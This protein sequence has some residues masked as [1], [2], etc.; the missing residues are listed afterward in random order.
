MKKVIIVGATSGIGRGLA[1]LMAND[2]CMVGITGRR[3]RLLDE[4]KSEMPDNYQAETFDVSDIDS[5]GQH[6]RE[7]TNRL[8]GLDLL[9]IS[10][11]AGYLNDMLDFELEKQTIDTN[12]TGFTAIADWAF[13]YFKRQKHGHL[14]AISSIAGLRGNRQSP[15]YSATKAYQ[16]IYLE[17]LRN[18]AA[19]S[20]LPI[21]ITDIRPGFVNTEMAKSDVLFWVAPV[22]K[23]V[24]Q[25]YKAIRS[26]RRVAYI[27]KRWKLIGNVVKI[28]PK[29][30]AEN[31]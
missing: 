16:I 30:I 14:V 19:K 29:R 6:L 10:S 21:F 15:A 22:E 20:G 13:N 3:T 8:G 11:G 31:I 5:V 4:I 18:K 1:K 24:S 12:V 26:R 27:T 28:L 23:A 2:G 17:G 25:I 9:V 7:L